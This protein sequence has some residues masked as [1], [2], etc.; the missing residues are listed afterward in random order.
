MLTIILT[1]MLMGVSSNHFNY[2]DICQIHWRIKI[3][4]PYST[5]R[6]DNEEVIIMKAGKVNCYGKIPV[7]TT[8]DYNKF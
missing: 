2:E 5:T 3:K 8:H 4:K 1:M 6:T 7:V